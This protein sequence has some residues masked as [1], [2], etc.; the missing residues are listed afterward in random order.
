[1]PCARSATSR[2][3]IRIPNWEELDNTGFGDVACPTPQEWAVSNPAVAIGISRAGIDYGAG[4]QTSHIS[5]RLPPD[6]GANH[7]IEVLAELSGK[8]IE[9]GFID[10]LLAAKTPTDA[11][12]LL[13]E[14]KR[15]ASRPAADK[16]LHHRRHRL[17]GR[18]RPHY[19]AAESPG[20]AAKKLGYE[21]K[22]ETNGSIGVKNSPTAAEIARA[23]AIVACDK[24]VD[25]ACF[26][27]KPLIKTGVKAPSRMARD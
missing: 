2:P 12:A 7:H 26:N 10:A 16:G 8:L 23:S 24:Q 3:F 13:L 25:M 22:V 5:S 20:S 9:E 14:K 19:L 18:H 4:W 11:L 17:P 15:R 1:M 27:G 21:V 6:G